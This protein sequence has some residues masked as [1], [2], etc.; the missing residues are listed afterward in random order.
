MKGK[1]YISRPLCTIA[2]DDGVVFMRIV[3]NPSKIL[4]CDITT[5]LCVCF[6]KTMKQNM[7]K[8]YKNANYSPFT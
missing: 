1:I 8:F 4:I 2:I 5:L 6:L 7:N 3:T